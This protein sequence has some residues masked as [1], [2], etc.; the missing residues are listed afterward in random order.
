MPL[1][2]P[3]SCITIF[4]AALQNHS[5]EMSWEFAL[6]KTSQGPYHCVS[7]SADRL[8]SGKSL[9]TCASVC[10]CVCVCMC[11][12]VHAL[13]D[14][15]MKDVTGGGKFVSDCLRSV[16]IYTYTILRHF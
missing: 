15:L 3:G 10:M 6:K 11:M 16:N 8:N 4:T 7:S 1:L 2:I 9:C 12:C 13:L 5:D 14:V